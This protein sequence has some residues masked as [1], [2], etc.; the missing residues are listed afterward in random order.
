M[1]GL[2]IA[3]VAIVSAFGCGIVAWGIHAL[4]E[5][6]QGRKGKT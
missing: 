5:W 2:R 3:L 6:R 1:S 4:I